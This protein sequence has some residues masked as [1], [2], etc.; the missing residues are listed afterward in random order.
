MIMT[1]NPIVRNAALSKQLQTVPVGELKLGMVVHAIAEQAGKLGVKS[2]GEIKHLRIIDQLT[3]SG[4]K[5]VLVEYPQRK[6]DQALIKLNAQRNKVFERKKYK[7]AV[8]ESIEP[9]DASNNQLEF[10]NAANLLRISESIYTNF[11]TAI[12]KNQSIDFTETKNL[13][14]NVYASLAKTPDALLCM[15]MIMHS[16]DYIANHSI[17]VATLL[18]YFAH[19]LNCPKDE[20]EKLALIGYLFD[21]GM[22]KIPE[23]IRL[24]KGTLTESEQDEM[25]LHVAYSLNI[26]EPLKLD[27]EYLLA[28]EQHH[29]RLNGSGYPYGYSGS[30]IH[31]FSRMLAIVDC[32]DALTTAR[33][34]QLPLS[35]AAAM[36][37]LSNPDHGYDQKLVLQF[38]R[39]MGIYPVGSLVVLSNKR[40][41]LVTKT[42]RKAPTSPEVKVF[43]SVTGNHFVS[44]EVIN[45][46]DVASADKRSDKSADK[47]VKSNNKGLRVLKPVLASQ[48][49]LKMENIV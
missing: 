20:C 41:G 30:K 11:T 9:V 5:S 7:A 15:S 4:V 13:V 40:I 42:N 29:E 34:H 39:C 32:Y 45:L 12:H 24:K 43:Y 47:K 26:L 8:I 25:K 48:F 14:A 18:C 33:E 2:K 23:A 37:V 35:P 49:G 19:Q 44:P 3:A 36:K 31:K 1:E 6:V 27:R 46:F 10:D 28:V 17:H 38:I 16:S 21:V 22:V